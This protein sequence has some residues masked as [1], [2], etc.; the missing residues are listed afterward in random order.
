MLVHHW[1]LRNESSVEPSAIS[2]QEY[3]GNKL[4]TISIAVII[5]NC[6]F[7]ILRFYA[8]SITKA[9]YVV[10][11][12]GG[13]GRHI[14]DVL[15]NDPELEIVWAKGT[16]ATDLIYLPSVALPKLSALCFCLRVFVFRK[17]RIFTW[18]VIGIVIINW[19]AFTISATL[20]CRPLAYWWDKTI[21]GGFCIDVQLL[22]RLACIPNLAIDVMVLALPITS[23]MQLRLPLFKKIA[24]CFI[25]LT[26]SVGMLASIY[27]F[28]LFISV[29]GFDDRT[30][31]TVPLLAWSVVECSMYLAAACLPLLRP[32]VD[33]VTPQ[34]W[35][36]KFSIYGISRYNRT[37]C[38]T[39]HSFN[40]RALSSNVTKLG[41]HDENSDSLEMGH[42][43]TFVTEVNGRSVSETCLV[44]P[45]GIEVTNEISVS[46]THIPRQ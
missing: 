9:A 39:N 33:K 45:E 27:R 14:W 1:Q 31:A 13:A 18:I 3:C 21:Q 5:L 4:V 25:F 32:V 34:K 6:V 17:V 11:Y 10:V 15:E 23:L 37:E 26:G 8:R 22:F 20:Q 24:L 42:T 46:V 44:P 35:K 28:L 7:V 16:I 2:N 43:A 36:A 29:D 41:V 38:S 12:R 30:W 19:A 40:S